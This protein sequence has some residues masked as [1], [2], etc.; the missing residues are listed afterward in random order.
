MSAIEASPSQ[1]IETSLLNRHASVSSHASYTEADPTTAYITPPPHPHPHSQPQTMDD[2]NL[3]SMD[4]EASPPPVPIQQAQQPQQQTPNDTEAQDHDRMAMDLDVVAPDPDAPAP[5]V[6]PPPQ[7]NT[8]LPPRDGATATDASAPTIGA[9]VEE[10][11]VVIAVQTAPEASPTAA[12]PLPIPVLLDEATQH[13]GETRPG[14]SPEDHTDEDEDDEEEDGRDDNDDESSDDEDWWEG[15]RDFHD[16]LKEDTSGPSEEELKEMERHP[17]RTGLDH[18]QFEKTTFTALDDPEY[19]P[20]ASGRVTWT[21]KGFHGT[22]E[23]PNKQ[24]IMRSDPVSIGGYKWRV[25]VFPHG[26]D[27]TEHVSVYVECCGPAASAAEPNVVSTEDSGMQDMSG[28]SAAANEAVEATAVKDQESATSPDSPIDGSWEVAAQ[29]GCAMYNPEEPRVYAFDKSNYQFHHH[30]SDCGW[31]RFHGPWHGLHKRRH[32]QRA[33]MLRNDTLAFTA[34]IRVIDDPTKALWY[35]GGEDYGW[36][37]ILKTGLR[38]LSAGNSDGNSL[39]AA[40]TPWLHLQPFKQLVLETSCPSMVSQPRKPVRPMFKVIQDAIYGKHAPENHTPG[41]PE[42]LSPIRRH[43]R[44]Y[45]LNIVNTTDAIQIWETLRDALNEEYWND[46]DGQ[47]RP[48]VLSFVRT[49]KQNIRPSLPTEKVEQL[50]LP[51]SVQELVDRASQDDQTVYRDWE[52]YTSGGPNLPAVLQIELCRQRY[53]PETRKWKRLT[54]QIKLDESITVG[55]AEYTLFAMIVSK[56]ELGSGR[57]YPIV[58]SAGPTSQWAR[59]KS[60][61]VT[62]LTRRQAIESHEGKGQA[63]EG[64]ESVAQI[65]MYVRSDIGQDSLPAA[66]FAPTSKVMFPLEK[67]KD[68][69][70]SSES[71]QVVVHDSAAFPQHKGQGIVDL[72]SK[73]DT[74]VYE[75][76]LKPSATLEDVQKELL[77]KYPSANRH[78]QFRLWPMRPA[79]LF[80]SRNPAHGDH[81]AVTLGDASYEEKLSTLDTFFNGVRLWMAFIPMD[82]I[83]LEGADTSMQQEAVADQDLLGAQSTISSGLAA[84]S[85]TAAPSHAVDVDNHGASQ[86]S[87][88]EALRLHTGSNDAWPI[89]IPPGVL[90]RTPGNHS[91]GVSDRLRDLNGGPPPSILPPQDVA[92]GGTQ[93][94]AV[95][96]SA[97]DA[98]EADTREAT[99]SASTSPDA[100]PPQIQETSPPSVLILVKKRIPNWQLHQDTYLIFKSFDPMAQK[101]Q[102]LTSGFYPKQ[103]KLDDIVA[104]LKL[105][106]ES[107]RVVTES[108]PI[109]DIDRSVPND[110]TIGGSHLGDGDVLVI[111]NQVSENDKEIISARGEDVSY[112]AYYNRKFHDT[113]FSKRAKNQSG[114][115]F[116]GRYVHGSQHNGQLQGDCTIV[117]TSGDAYRGNVVAGEYHGQGTMYFAN[118]NN[119]TGEWVGG[120]PEGQGTMLFNQ[121]GNRYVGGWRA[122][123]K[124][125]RGVMYYEVAD[126]EMQLC[127]ICY[128]NEMDA[129][130]FRCG[131]VAAC[132]S[133][134]RQVN[135]CPVCRRPVDAVVRMW[136]T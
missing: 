32:L 9:A 110:S 42:S 92:M 93:D 6:S 10:P 116:G 107:Y 131:H 109:T 31:V 124:H 118:G 84:A 81:R 106:F 80:E 129:L 127:K 100:S 61:H 18:V 71:F 97:T 15:Q 136:K 135:D 11:Q 117:Q 40:L 37:S 119:Y 120:Q 89:D 62:F 115:Y 114:S 94:E 44:L 3:D 98:N 5:I 73:D 90:D 85:A 63:R 86:V 4:H 111:V 72:W 28:E 64:T 17:E 53:D 49:I 132:E 35:R 102:N 67:P 20:A 58:R 12:P 113:H 52:G 96:E 1:S 56:G 77:K 83:K 99:S 23:A 50:H 41:Y 70:T 95:N 133:C 7:Q 39:I 33:A 76:T 13:S 38:G 29:V 88:G 2:A 104:E 74:H 60:H 91:P 57:M 16:R 122:G 79:H 68:T 51:Q 19:R 87:E 47:D 30:S 14:G 128:E 75:F 25:K 45:G 69:N 54:H 108:E 112:M 26:Y 103:A 66:Q 134:A 78:D 24:R 65:V 48:D 101:V 82:K 8:P 121:T 36:D 130:F 27:G 21:L 125:G 34:Y 55:D 59:Y 22:K 123:R 105:P 46:T 126:E 43:L